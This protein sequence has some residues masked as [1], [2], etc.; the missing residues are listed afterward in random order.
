MGTR[1]MCPRG[2]PSRTPAIMARLHQKSICK[3]RKLCD[4]TRTAL[5]SKGTNDPLV[6]F[7]KTGTNWD[8]TGHNG[9]LI[10]NNTLGDT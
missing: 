7:V 1:S 8:D 9:N 5:I 10:L 3:R 4:I 2:Y 6:V